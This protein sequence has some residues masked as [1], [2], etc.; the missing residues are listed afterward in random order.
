MSLIK[1]NCKGVVR[2][3]QSIGR[4]PTHSYVNGTSV[5]SFL[6][7]AGKDNNR[8]AAAAADDDDKATMT[9]TTTN[10]QRLT[11]DLHVISFCILKIG[12]D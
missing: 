7:S 4:P 6:R 10:Q 5:R 3:R 9:M 8:I 11:E 2:E 1:N 12:F